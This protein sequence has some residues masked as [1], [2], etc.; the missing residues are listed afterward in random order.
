MPEMGISVQRRYSE[1][2]TGKSM[3]SQA[4]VDQ[5]EVEVRGIHHKVVVEVR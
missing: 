3:T 5:Y 4:E 2:R 1:L